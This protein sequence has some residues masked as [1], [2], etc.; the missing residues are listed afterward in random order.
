M[1][2]T[3]RE[4]TQGWIAGT[5]I[6]IIILTFALWGIHSYFVSGAGNNIVAVVNGVDITK[7][8]LTVAYE[9]LRRQMQSQYAS[10]AMKDDNSL[11]SRALNGIVELEVLKQSSLGQGFGV[12]DQQVDGYLQSMPEFQVEG[13]FSLDR[14]QEILSSTMLSI[15]EFLE[16]IRTGLLID[17][18]RLGTMLTSFAL[19]DETIRTVALVDQERNIDYVTI[20]LQYFVSQ[21]ITIPAE[22]IESYYKEHQNE[23]MTPDQVNLDY[24]ELTLKDLYARFSPTDAMLKNFY[25]ENI[26]S[27]T[28]PTAWKLDSLL[29]AVP[30]NPSQADWTSAQNKMEKVIESLDKGGNFQT[31]AQQH[32]RVSM[33]KGLL[34]L[35]QVPA[36]L[37]KAAAGLTTVG[38]VSQPIKTAQGI[39]ILKADE[40]REPKI[41]SFEQVKDKVR[42]VYVRQHAEEKFAEMRDQLADLT[43]ANPNSLQSAA[44]D[45]GLTVKSTELFTKDKPGKDISQYKKVRDA[46]F[47]NE[48]LNLQNNSDVIQ[49]NPE[50]IA[51]IRVKSH[52]ASKLL[53]LNDISNQIADKL[54]AQEADARAEKFAQDLK[55]Q[56][57]KGGDPLALVSAEK[58][59]WT[60]LGYIGRYSTKVDSAVMDTAFRLPAATEGRVVYGVT[61]LPGGY[62][63]V[64]MHGVK[65]GSLDDKKMGVFSEQVQNSLGFLE[66]SLY[67]DSQMNK[68]KIK[69]NA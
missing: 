48:V 67:K 21:P 19:P 56:L 35:N 17:Q 44:N 37:Q 16:I 58:F 46:A 64:A 7:E 30:A 66:Y 52:L 25:S 8:Q 40:I 13:R 34:V 51:V 12:S 54:K 68:A 63:V 1:L 61:R 24:V 57:E 55:A 10:G 50:T 47:S 9:R 38:Q 43:Y 49:L 26:N 60:R 22:R 59:V 28:Q 5:I 3:I 53:P 18:P 32:A 39:V 27:Y 31:M 4:R 2:Q 42:E 69:L 20:P 36:E 45:M 6:S 15:S 62:G 14:F 33:P 65:N 23:Y 29:I 41:E 11:K